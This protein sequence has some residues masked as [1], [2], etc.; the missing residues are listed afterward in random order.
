M[1]TSEAKTS[2]FESK[3]V[4]IL[5][6]ITIKKDEKSKKEPT[7]FSL[8]DFTIFDIPTLEGRMDAIRKE[9]QPKFEVMGTYLKEVL[10]KN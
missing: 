10:E 3:F 8:D 4:T 2:F 6:D 1:I 9:I 7:M 5:N